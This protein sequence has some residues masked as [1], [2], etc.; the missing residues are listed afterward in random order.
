MGHLVDAIRTFFHTMFPS[1]SAEADNINSLFL[2]YLILAGVIMLV[3]AIMVILGGYLYRKKVR[4]E[5]PPQTFGNRRAEL[6]WTII[7]FIA[8]TFFFVLTIRSMEAINQ[9]LHRRT[10]S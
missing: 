2:N 7:P 9:T 10:G 4:P 1:A 8:V 6:L 5:V 3:V